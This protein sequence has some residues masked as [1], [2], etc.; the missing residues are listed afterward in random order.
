MRPVSEA[1]RQQVAARLRALSDR[2][3]ADDLDA[4]GWDA[5]GAD[6]DAAL[7]RFPGEVADRT[8]FARGPAEAVHHP[9]AEGTSGVYPPV[10]LAIDGNRLTADVRFGP[11]WEGPPDLVHGGYLAA[12]FDMVLSALASHVCG[13]TVTRRL[14]VR[15]LKPTFQASAL[16]YECEA[17]EP[18]GRLIELR[19]V[20]LADGQVTMRASAQFA[21]IDEARFLDRRPGATHDE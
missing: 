6:L 3:A 10:E 17:S 7:A 14:Q 15:Y 5:L 9:I 18:E 8:R 19:G 11:A 13:H 2:L 1:Q 4:A 16:R 21:R 12:G 20:L